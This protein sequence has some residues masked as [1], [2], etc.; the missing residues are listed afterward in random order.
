MDMAQELM[1]AYAYACASIKFA[2]KSHCSLA[3]SGDKCSSEDNQGQKSKPARNKI[4]TRPLCV[5]PKRD[6]HVQDQAVTRMLP[7]HAMG[8]AYRTHTHDS[9][10]QLMHSCR[11]PDTGRRWH[12][13]TCINANLC[14]RHTPRPASCCHHVGSAKLGTSG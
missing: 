2:L 13:R 4:R 6:L 5:W 1:H 10:A 7:C 11:G 3:T 14:M 9:V 8:V 12:A